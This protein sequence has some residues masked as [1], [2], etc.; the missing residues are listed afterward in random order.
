VS[1]F[2]TP[3]NTSVGGQPVSAQAT[4]TTGA[5]TVHIVVQNL[6]TDPR[7]VIQNLSA[8]GFIL[9][10]G[11]SA[12]SL[13][14]SSANLRSVASSN[15]TDSGAASTGWQL[16]SGYSLSSV[17]GL[18]LCDLCSGAAGP[19][20]TLLG[21]PSGSGGYPNANASIDGNGPHNPFLSGA[22]VYDLN[23]PGVT[24]QTTVS[25]VR[26]Q[27]GT[28]DGTNFVDVTTLLAVEQRTWDLVKR[29]YR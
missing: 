26:F 20:H 28:A 8:L 9:G 13:V 2:S 15:F 19:A 16:E 27:F 18:R 14:S 5:G 25:K 4:F 23:V 12:G 17:L 6:I 7:S 24:A 3:A 22:A 29:L 21:A 11:Q 1:V 10:G